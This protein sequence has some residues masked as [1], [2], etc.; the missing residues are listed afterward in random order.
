MAKHIRASY[1]NN[2]TLSLKDLDGLEPLRMLVE[3]GVDKLKRDYLTSFISK[4]NWLCTEEIWILGLFRGYCT[5]NLKLAC[6][7]CYLKIIN[8]FSKK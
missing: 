1:M 2:V 7:V 8:T 4:W 5:P 3:I 6:F